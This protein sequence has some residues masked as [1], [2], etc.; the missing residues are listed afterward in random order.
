MDNT[1]I[2]FQFYQIELGTPLP[3]PQINYLSYNNTDSIWNNHTPQI[4]FEIKKSD[5]WEDY[6]VF[7][8]LLPAPWYVISGEKLSDL[9]WDFVVV[10]EA[11]F[12]RA[13]LYYTCDSDF[14]ATS[15]SIFSILFLARQFCLSYL[16]GKSFPIQFQGRAS[17]F[18]F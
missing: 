3:Q 5:T 2:F 15:R 7:F 14:I 16:R 6:I 9:S 8:L 10:W 17:L 4:M 1:F 13:S 11:V 18:S 12:S